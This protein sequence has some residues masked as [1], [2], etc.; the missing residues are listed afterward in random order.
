M[1][2]E[3]PI[4]PWLRRG[5]F[6]SHRDLC[7]QIHVSRSPSLAASSSPLPGN[8]SST[9]SNAA[10]H[11]TFT[12]AGDHPASP[13][14]WGTSSLFSSQSGFKFVSPCVCCCPC[15]SES[16]SRMFSTCLS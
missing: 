15:A 9:V 11:F 6:Y 13:F 7:V 2:P 4:H 12:P 10:V 1:G 5:I 16:L 8:K 14:T 3:K